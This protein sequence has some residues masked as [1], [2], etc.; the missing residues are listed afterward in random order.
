MNDTP[1]PAERRQVAEALQDRLVQQLLD[2][3]G[4]IPTPLESREQR[5]RREKARL[6]KLFEQAV[7]G[8]IRGLE[9]LAGLK[10][11]ETAEIAARWLRHRDDIEA[12][13][14]SV[15]SDAEKAFPLFVDAA[16]A[17]LRAGDLH[18]AADAT[19]V[20]TMVFPLEPQPY[21][22]LG[23]VIWK[24]EGL[25]AAVA[26]YDA[27]LQVLEHPMIHYFAA[28]CFATAGDPGRARRLLQDALVLCDDNPEAAA[29][30]RAR[31]EAFQAELDA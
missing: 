3:Q 20:L 23:T 31:I 5:S 14:Q 18:R 19:S 7:E 26:Y 25:K 12:L 28:D 27:L 6:K 22:I 16:I 2:G 10:E 9:V 21:S 30:F 15:L 1:S 29:G 8:F 24:L 4:F 13:A 11:P 17:L